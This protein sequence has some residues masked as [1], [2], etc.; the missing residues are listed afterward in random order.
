M[1]FS[2]PV[3]DFHSASWRPSSLVN[4]HKHAS[5]VTTSPTADRKTLKPKQRVRFSLQ[6]TVDH[7]D[8]EAEALLPSRLDEVDEDGVMDQHNNDEL[9]ASIN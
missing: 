5:S 6:P 3:D 1:S 8:E 2:L 9:S 7:S 4:G